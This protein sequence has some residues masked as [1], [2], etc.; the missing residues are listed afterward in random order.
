MLAVRAARKKLFCGQRGPVWSDAL[1][2]SRLM[3]NGLGCRAPRPIRARSR[4]E[5][6]VF[7]RWGAWAARRKERG[8]ARKSRPDL[9]SCEPARRRRRSRAGTQPAARRGRPSRAVV[10]AVPRSSSVT[11]PFD[12]SIVGSAHVA[13]LA[14]FTCRASPSERLTGS[15]YLPHNSS[16]IPRGDSSRSPQASRVRACR[17]DQGTA[18]ASRSGPGVRRV[19]APPSS[20][21]DRTTT[22]SP[23]SPTGWSGSSFILY[24]EHIA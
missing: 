12:A 10:H 23:Q 15:P 19:G 1:D 21:S 5:I 7:R 6:R 11:T 4:A 8:A 2:A 24:R 16:R 17:R 9:A 20:I 14:R 18:R 3:E 22:R 13:G